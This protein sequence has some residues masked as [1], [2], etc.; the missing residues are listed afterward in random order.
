MPETRLE[1]VV[2]SFLRGEH[3]VLVCTSIIEN[4]LDMPNVNTLIVRQAEKLGLA[5]LY[6]LRGRVGRSNRVAY[7]YFTYEPEKVLS[8]VAQKR[9]LALREFTELGSGF[10]LAL[11]DLEIR[12]A[13]NI[14]GAEQH[15]HIAAV[16]FEMYWRLLEEAVYEL[17][18]KAVSP[19]LEPQV[20]L[21][22]NAYLPASYVPSARDKMQLYKAIAACRKEEE[23]TEVADDIIDRY[24]EPPQEVVSLLEVARLKAL[25]REV[26][27]AGLTQKG[28]QVILTL[29]PDMYLTPEEVIALIRSSQ[30]RLAPLPGKE[31]ELL[32]RTEGLLPEQVSTAVRHML[33]Q[34][35]E[36]VAARTLVSLDSKEYNVT[37]E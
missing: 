17:Q 6:Q 3:N 12:G 14:L 20:D 16:G 32:F 25:A 22:L 21:A 1:R 26:G 8:T 7:A 15:G 33:Q 4:G 23:V 31:R 10:K 37:N 28:Q 9:L 34:I 24:G 27:I 13:G 35:K 29:V 19:P 18:G 5:Q 36:L 2:L 30:R 11:R